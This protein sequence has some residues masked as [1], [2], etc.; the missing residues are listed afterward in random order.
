MPAQFA[1]YHSLVG[2]FQ[3]GLSRPFALVVLSS[4]CAAGEIRPSFYLNAC[5]WNA[6]E[7]LVV[8]PTGFAGTFRVIETIKGDLEP[9]KTLELSGLTSSQSVTAKL[10][11]LLKEEDFNHPFEDL[12]PI[13]LGDRLIVF[14][15]RPGAFPE[16]VPRPDLPIDTNGWQRA[17]HMGDLRA[18]AVWIQDGITY[19]FLQTNNPGPTQLAML[20]M[21]EDE[22][23]QGIQSVLRSRDASDKA[24]ATADPVERSRQLAALV[25]SGNEIARMS[26]LQKLQQGGVPEANALLDLLS[27]QT[28]L[29]WHQDMIGALVGKRV[30]DATFGE[31]LSDETVYW[32]R[33]CR[34]LNPGWWNGARYPDVETPR[35]HYTRANSLLKAIREL[36]LSAA[37]PVVRDFAAI[38][39][40]CP[41]LEAR[42]KANQI[43]DELKSLLG[44]DRH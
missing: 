38:W 31:F 15:R 39:N 11:E 26:A 1:R 29:G 3:W 5:S 25:R 23:R 32:S 16:Y 40:T 19:G 27:D 35:G 18:S 20:R 2:R 42:E 14:L 13:G 24:V 17:N 36:R 9:G 37:M 44:T 7:I 10:R 12:P 41:P 43:T 22:L 6:T 4:L 33:A 28:L 8:T 30:A 34:T 21:S